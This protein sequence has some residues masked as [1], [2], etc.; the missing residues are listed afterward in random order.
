MEPGNRSYLKNRLSNQS[1]EQIIENLMDQQ[2]IGA[3]FIVS[4]YSGWLPFSVEF[5]ASKSTVEGDRSIQKYLWDFGDGDTGE[6]EVVTHEYTITGMFDIQLTIIDNI[7]DT[8]RTTEQIQ[9][10]DPV[11]S[12]DHYFGNVE[13]YVRFQNDLWSTQIDE[14]NLRLHLSNAT[15]SSD[16]SLPGY[17]IIKDSLYFDFT[18][19]ITTRIDEDLSLNSLAEYTII[20]GYEDENNYNYMLMKQTTSRLVNVTNRQSIDM[21]RATQMGIPDEQYHKVTLN[22]SDDQLTVILD[23][24]LFLT[25]TSSRLKKTG[26]IGFGSSNYAVFFDD[27]AVAGDA[28]PAGINHTR[29]IPGHFKLWQ[30]YPNPF[31][32]S[33]KIQFTLLRAENVKIEIYNSR[34]QRLKTLVN[35]LMPAG[36]H[37]VVFSGE[38]MVSGLYFYTMQAGEFHDVKKMVLLK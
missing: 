6:G 1:F 12:P 5:D 19:N 29:N 25:T 7:G 8:L 18:L 3:H 32:P 2:P 28:I 9:V 13:N 36:F 26:K 35:R 37:A 24:S 10:S 22:L 15:R 33:T 34:G 17:T 27:I 16:I 30:N 38:D 20:F 31:N 21:G 14:E 23:D 11:F 4:A